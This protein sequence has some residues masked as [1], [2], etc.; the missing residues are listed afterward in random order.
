MKIS[1]KTLLVLA[2]FGSFATTSC[3]EKKAE[4][5]ATNAGDAMGNAADSVKADIAREPGDTAVVLDQPANKVVEQM[6]ATPQK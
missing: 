5:T 1:F 6:P 3:S 4:D 2:A